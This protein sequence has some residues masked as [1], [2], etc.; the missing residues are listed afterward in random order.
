MLGQLKR[1]Q[2]SNYECNKGNK[3]T[4]GNV[5]HAEKKTKLHAEL[6]KQSPR[7]GIESILGRR[8]DDDFS[9]NYGYSSI[10]NY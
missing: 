6:T 1:L 10:V 5:K 2:V 3:K 9:S 4:K 7:I 8:D